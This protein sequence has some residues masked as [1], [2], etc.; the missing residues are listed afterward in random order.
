MNSLNNYSFNNIKKEI[1]NIL[2]C[3]GHN[4]YGYKLQL[5]TNELYKVNVINT[6]RNQHLHGN[7]FVGTSALHSLNIAAWAGQSNPTSEKIQQIVIFDKSIQVKHFWHNLQNM[8]INHMN[9][10]ACQSALRDHL[11]GNYAFYFADYEDEDLLERDKDAK[12]LLITNFDALDEE[13]QIGIS[14]FSTDES[15]ARIREI[16]LNGQFIFKQ[17]DYLDSKVFQEIGKIFTKNQLKLGVLYLSNIREYSLWNGNHLNDF[18][19]SVMSILQNDALVIDTEPRIGGILEE[20]NPLIPRITGIDLS[21]SGNHE[22][23]EELFDQEP[24]N[25][26]KMNVSYL[27]NEEEESPNQQ[28]I[29]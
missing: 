25:P 22:E 29:A 21:P 28:A 6:L 9:R 5:I 18:R 1:S 7:T 4:T 8:F 23:I 19:D 17:A 2:E 16:F 20:C 13:I 26:K 10:N 12:N 14:C 3:P 27:L 15:Y 11:R 24:P